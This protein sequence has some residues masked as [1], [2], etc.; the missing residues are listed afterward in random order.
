MH[1]YKA[2]LYF[3]QRALAIRI[4]L[5]CE[6]DERTAHCYMHLKVAQEL[7]CKDKKTNQKRAICILS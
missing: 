3:Y 2:A 7:L 6:E 5:L 1:D 4:K